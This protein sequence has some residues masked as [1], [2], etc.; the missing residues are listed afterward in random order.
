MPEQASSG[1]RVELI[2][3]NDPY[4]RLRP[5]DRGTVMSV[6]DIGTVHVKWDHGS[7]LGLVTASGD[8]YRIIE[9][10]QA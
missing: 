6:D 8:S 7:V 3:C 5:G 10:A 2:R 9:E 1:T 4:T